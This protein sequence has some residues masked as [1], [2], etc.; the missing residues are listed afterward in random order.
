MAL[1][2]VTG[3]SGFI[4][5]HLV[6]A[7]LERGDTVRV[8]DNF[9]TG[10]RSNLAEVA[11]DIDLRTGSIT[12]RETVSAAMRGV[13]YVL[14]QAAIPSV[15]RSVEQPYECHE[16]NVTGTLN[17]LVA[18]R[19]AGV[20]KVVYAA[21]SSAYGNTETLPKCETI[22]PQPLSP[23]A[24]AK[25]AGEQY[26]RVFHQVYGLPTVALRY[27]NIFGPRQDPESLYAAVVPR[28]ITM[29]LQG[30]APT[31]NGDGGQS[32]D[33]TYV[34]NVVQANLLAC[35]AEERAH[36]QVM[37]I[38]CGQAYTLLDLVALL[39]SLL[40]TSIEPIHA[41][42]QVGDVRH[43]LAA[44]ECA[45]KLIGYTPVVG[46]AEGIEYT[47]ASLRTS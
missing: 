3:G 38:A 9:V 7:L 22:N 40:G 15:A 33:F 30:K 32:R 11:A 17:I 12:D 35:A 5:S 8:L 24:A 41:P 25:L 2:L 36:G 46:F 23:Y 28:F 34:A 10:R 26:C 45:T 47:I 43:S 13:E 19:D 27:F 6:R 18:A 44:I 14:H 31:I 29:M 39:N 4:G 20:R 21:S 1:Y 37:N 42:P 16:S